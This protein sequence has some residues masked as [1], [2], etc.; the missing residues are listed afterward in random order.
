ML[1]VMD[2]FTKGK[3]IINHTNNTLVSPLEYY[4]LA[5]DNGRI[6]ELA[7]YVP[8]KFAFKTS[9]VSKKYN[10]LKLKEYN[11]L[12]DFLEFNKKELREKWQLTENAFRDVEIGIEMNLI[13]N[14]SYF[15]TLEKVIEKVNALV[16]RGI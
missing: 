6:R 13:E 3:L 12:S 9:I 8:K 2:F 1:K 4:I 16:R 14:Y 5:N 7:A 15:N 11:I 10:Q